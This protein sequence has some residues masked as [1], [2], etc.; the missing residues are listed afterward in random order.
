MSGDRERTEFEAMA[1]AADG[2]SLRHLSSPAR[3]TYWMVA[4]RTRS[5]SR[6]NPRPTRRSGATAMGRNRGQ[7]KPYGSRTRAR[8]LAHRPG[9]RAWRAVDNP[10]AKRSYLQYLVGSGAS[11]SRNGSGLGRALLVPIPMNAATRPVHPVQLALD[12]LPPAQHSI[13]HG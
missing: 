10:T 1:A 11:V 2:G 4:I 9:M 3:Q 13:P 8:E 6:R 5:G 7:A 12:G